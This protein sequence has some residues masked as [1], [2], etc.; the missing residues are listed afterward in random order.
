MCRLTVL[1][2]LSLFLIL[3]GC[4]KTN[5]DQQ[6]N[7]LDRLPEKLQKIETE[8]GDWQKQLHI[9]GMSALIVKDNEIVW[10]KGYGYADWAQKI[11]AD[12]HTPYRLGSLTKMFSAT[13]LLQLVQAGELN[14]DDSIAPYFAV[15]G[16]VDGRNPLVHQLI[17]LNHIP[18]PPDSLVPL[19]KLTDLPADI[20]IRHLLSHTA[21]GIPGQ[22]FHF[23]NRNFSYLDRVLRQKTDSDFGDLLVKTIIRQLNLVDTAPGHHHP[24]FRN[25]VQRLAKPYTVNDSREIIPSEYPDYFSSAAGAISSVHDLGLFDRALNDSTLLNRETRR[26]MFTPQAVDWT[27]VLPHSLGWFVQRLNNTVVIWNFG[28]WTGNSGL[29]IKIPD[30]HVTFIILANSPGLCQGFDLV[31][32]GITRSPFALAFLREFLWEE[33]QLPI[34]EWSAGPVNRRQQ[35]SR[36]SDR[37]T[38][39][40]CLE[41]LLTRSRVMMMTGQI[42]SAKSLMSEFAA[43]QARLNP[44]EMA[45]ERV[46]AQFVQVESNRDLA[47]EL[48]LADSLTV[49]I[50]ALGEGHD[51]TMYDYGWIESAQTGEILWEMTYENSWH[52]GGTIKNRVASDEVWLAP[53]IYTLRYQSDETHAFNDWNE[54]PPTNMHYWGITVLLSTG[55]WPGSR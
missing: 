37:A 47:R 3:S 46:L 44:L 1:F 24:D 48:I 5:S 50:I 17:K 35:F 22:D 45:H 6:Q 19:E 26:M 41:E 29:F 36:F 49:R 32:S 2:I 12:E 23:N 34:T 9:P 31:D 21:D 7:S 42:D 53:G 54:P 38:A 14:I 13:L 8:L 40:Y 52:A 33:G 55:D 20:T 43:G 4:Q 39:E 25:V 16:K 11:P 15:A 27:V 18:M 30:R 10:Q 28:Q 51:G